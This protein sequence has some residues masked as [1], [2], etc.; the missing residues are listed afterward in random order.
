MRR[1]VRSFLVKRR[2]QVTVVQDGRARAFEV[3]V[4]HAQDGHVTLAET[5]PYGGPGDAGAPLASDVRPLA[6]AAARRMASD[7]ARQYG[8]RITEVLT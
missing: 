6:V 1:F 2:A 4:W 8:V 5:L 3:W 7:L